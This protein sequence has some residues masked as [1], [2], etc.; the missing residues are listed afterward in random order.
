MPLTGDGR[1]PRKQDVSPS[2]LAGW[3]N[4]SSALPAEETLSPD[5]TPRSRRGVL[6]STSTP[7]SATSAPQTGLGFFASS[8]T[9]LKTRLTSNA[10]LPGPQ[11]D[12]ELANLDIETALQPP[13][14]FAGHETFSP[15][16]YKNLQANAIG[17]CTKMQNAYRRRTTE[18]EELQTER[19]AEEEEAEE[20]RMR[21]ESLKMQLE[22][23]AK[24]ADEQQQSMRRLMAELD[25]EK[26]ARQEERL[27]RDKIL[28]EGSMVN[29]DL[30]VDEEERRRWRK[31]GGTERSSASEFDMESL[32]S[33]ESESVF[34]RSRSPTIMTGTTESHFDVASSSSSTHQGKTQTLGVPPRPRSTREM[35]TL[36]KL[37]KNISG[38]VA[39]DG[40]DGPGGCK[41]CQGQDSSVAWDTVGLLRD[42]NK[43]LK[44]RVA[45]L[46]VAVEGALDLVN[47]VGL[48]V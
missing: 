45:D 6:S 44:L 13:E 39:R 21:V 19:A 5:T 18:L 10:S 31:S 20:A 12:D 9:A 40:S 11:L 26:R 41:N 29:E 16:A 36:Q 37:M 2:R 32:R 42:E 23:M 8:V 48:N 1:G 22:H 33:A 7:K 43:G 25:H 35:S 30:G 34:S 47:G 46:E 24:K 14:Q 27:A 3:W 38:E 4:G 28:A 15:A 17:L